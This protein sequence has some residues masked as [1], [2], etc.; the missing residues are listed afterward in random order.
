[1]SDPSNLKERLEIAAYHEAATSGVAPEET[2][3]GRAFDYIA[4][5]EEALEVFADFADLID[6]ETEGF[7]DADEFSLV[8]GGLELQRFKLAD[9]RRARAVRGGG[10]EEGSPSSSKTAA[11]PNA[12]PPASEVAGGG[13]PTSD[14]SDRKI[15]ALK[16]RLD[17]HIQW[18]DAAREHA[19][20]MLSEDALE[21]N[22]GGGWWRATLDEPKLVQS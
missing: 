2:L 11:R 1:M 4:K 14:G 19:R 3:E 22:A 13:E 17:R 18:G 8:Y 21:R 15:D 7:F 16:R 6:S 12:L 20:M 10:E 9:F 5:L